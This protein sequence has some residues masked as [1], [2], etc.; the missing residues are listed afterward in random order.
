MQ[1]DHQRIGFTRISD[2]NIPDSFYNRLKTGEDEIDTIFGDGILLGSTMTMISDPGVGKSIFCR[3]VLEKLGNAGYAVG[4]AS[5]EEDI[6]QIAYSAASLGI[7]NLQTAT[8]TDIDELCDAM[9]QFDVLVIDSFQTITTKRDLNSR[10]KVQYFCN[11]IVKSAKQHNCVV[12]V[13]V[14][15]TSSGE[16]R[17]GTTLP[18]AV[19]VNICILKDTDVSEE[20]RLIQVY[21]N[22]FG[23]TGKYEMEMTSSGY[24]FKGVYVEP[25]QPAKVAKIPISE[26]RKELILSITEP[27]HITVDRVMEEI[28][29]A[30]QTAANLLRE[31]TFER[32]LKKYGRGADAIWKNV[33]IKQIEI[34]ELCEREES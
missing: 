8:I 34:E 9:E 1:L 16:I 4:Y 26:Q 27:P 13:I 18:F 28:G 12:I 11:S 6:N 3:T 5:G 20:F 2:V 31:L 30:Y 23:R 7:K 33:E 32:K 10:T 22:R 17:G 25:E 24:I 19:D 29:V 15:K 21:K 14:Q